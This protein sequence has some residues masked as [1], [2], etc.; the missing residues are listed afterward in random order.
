VLLGRNFRDEEDRPGGPQ[1]AILS[2]ELWQDRF[3]GD[4]QILGKHMKLDG[5]DYTIVGVAKQYESIFGSGVMVPLQADLSDP[6]RS[7]RDLWV[8][9]TLRKGVT[10]EQADVRLNSVAREVQQKYGAA[11]PEYTGLQ[12]QYWNI[13]VAVTVGVQPVFK[14][15]LGAVGLL[16]LI[17][18][19]NVANL[20]LARTA[21][22]KKE[23]VL[24]VA[25]G[26]GRGR[27]VRQMLTENLMLAGAAATLGILIAIWSLPFV[28]HLIPESWMSTQPERIAV[29]FRILLGAIGVSALAGIFFAAFPAWKASREN[30]AETLKAGS[31]KMSGDRGGRLVRN[32]LMISEIALAFVFLAGA[33][34]MIQSYRNLEQ[35]DLGFRPEQLLT[36]QISLPATKYPG[37]AQISTFFEKAAERVSDLPGVSG[38]GFVTGLPMVDRTVDVTTQDFTIEGRPLENGATLANANYRVVSPGYFDVMGARLIRGRLLTSQDRAGSQLTMVINETMA[39]RYWRDS[40]PVG[41]R[42]H[43]ATHSAEAGNSG[44]AAR[45]ATVTIVGVVSDI[46]QIRVIDAPV[47]QEFYL[48]VSEFGGQARGMSLMVRGSRDAAALTSAIRQSIAS[49]DS[50]EPIY[51]VETMDQVVADSFGPKRIATVLLGFF[52]IVALILST[53]GIYAIVSYSVSQRTNEIGIRRALGAQTGDI[54][55]L[56]LW[57]GA[58]ITLL[59][60]SIGIV[61]AIVLNRVGAGLRYGTATTALLYEVNPL[62]PATFAAV[63]SLLLIV[64]L[65]ACWIPARRATQ[66]EPMKALNCE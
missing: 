63:G 33:A 2:Y 43:L 4:P 53:V 62:D 31:S 37:P 44:G 12:L 46:K 64:A 17:C 7:V 30:A 36:M 22:R 19:A 58:R 65:A 42:I 23:F 56:V 52:A 41:K 51:D 49:I 50:G 57:Q 29:N 1:V 60:I 39:R 54:L 28:V 14:L 45:D 10:W 35:V 9:V 13:Y 8:L 3:E 27:V 55:K 66:V 26:A 61:M 6:D 24:R 48:P 11:H 20:L 34:L 38:V 40:D 15:L 16:L 59:A 32:A 18:C 25:L 47:R 21:T 5:N